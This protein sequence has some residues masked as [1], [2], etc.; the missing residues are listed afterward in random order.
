M[1]DKILQDAINMAAAVGEIHM[2]YFRTK[3]LDIDTKT[4]I[5]DVV[6]K[7][8]KE[9]EALLVKEI[10]KRYPDHNIIGEETGRH[11][12]EGAKWSWVIDPLDGTNSYSQ[13]LPI[14]CVSI[15]VKY[16]DET[17]VGVVYA[18]YLD[19]LFTAVK[20]R[21]AFMQQGLCLGELMTPDRLHVTTK[22]DI[23]TCVLASGFPYDKAT[24]PANNI[25]NCQRII[26]K[27]R[28]FRRMGSAAYDL[29][30]TAMG[31]IDAYWEMD[32]KE[33]DACAGALIV[34]EAGGIIVPFRDDRNIS[35]I[36][37]PEILV[38]QLKELVR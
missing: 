6:T 12:H 24:N 13:G 15:G 4:S 29:C 36:A 35:I 11:I 5:Y 2:E 25:D 7:V 9:S 16:E 20:G 34:Q 31:T 14:F 19:E 32:L 8:D 18:P 26:P 3:A 37:G 38:N 21:G 17:Q 22:T 23:A 27:I 10:S 1:L 33:Y 28:G 30:S